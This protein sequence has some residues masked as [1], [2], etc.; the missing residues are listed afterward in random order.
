GLLLSFTNIVNEAMARQE[1]Q[2]LRK[3]LS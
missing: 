1:A 3:A 2:Q